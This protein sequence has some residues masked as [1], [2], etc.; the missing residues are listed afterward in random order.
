MHTTIDNNQR[1]FLVT[2]STG[3]TAFCNLKDLNNVVKEVDTRED[4]FSIFH[5]W[6]SKAKKVSKKYLRELFTAN[7][8]K[9]EFNY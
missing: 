5:F 6:N 3:K 4:Y 2:T 7:Q 9:Q 1:V 8:L